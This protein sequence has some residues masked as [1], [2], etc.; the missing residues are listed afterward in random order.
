MRIIR[1]TDRT[2]Q[3]HVG[4]DLGDGKAR[5]LAGEFPRFEA[6]GETV[7][8]VDLLPPIVPAD[9]LCIG[10]NYQA[11]ADETGSDV[12]EN[13]M[14]FIKSSNALAGPADAVVLPKNSKKV[15][16][17]AELVVVIGKDARHVAVSD[18]LD[19]VFGYTLA[20]DVSARDWQKDKA[21]NGGQFSRGKSFDGFCPLGPA[22]VTR[23]AIADP[24][25]LPIR[26]T[27]NGDV[28]QESNTSDMIFSVAQIVASL[29]ET[30]TVRAGSIILTGT[31]QGV[32]VARTPPIFLTPGDVAEVEV[33]GVGKLTTHFVAEP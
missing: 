11:H 27:L 3:P 6:T 5:L 25:N 2:G 7:D 24:N 18:A 10:L 26:C 4:E 28:V 14:L 30:M 23:D 16:Y 9:I 31:P 29:S 32:G 15:D 22:I 17:E 12:P 13:P 21:L 8:V 33:E 19:H 1:F 20:N